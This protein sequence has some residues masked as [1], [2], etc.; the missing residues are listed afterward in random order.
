MESD[1]VQQPLSCGFLILRGQPV[2]SFLLMRHPRRWDLPKGHL[3]EGETEIQCALRELHEETGIPADAVE[4]DPDFQYE[5]RY[6]V[7]QKR[8]GG[9]GLIEKRLLIFLGH[10]TRPIRIVVTEHDDYRWF[11]WNPPHHIQEWTIDPLLHA[12]HEHL[13]RKG[14]M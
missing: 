13:K 7:N 14:T 10:L 1:D 5:N 6:M 12:V 3:D 4:I 2:D 11:D 9:K 8:Y